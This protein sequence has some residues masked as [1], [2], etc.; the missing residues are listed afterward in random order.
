MGDAIQIASPNSI[1]Q[2]QNFRVEALRG[3][4]PKMHADVLQPWGGAREIRLDRVTGY[5]TYQ[6]VFLNAD[7]NNTGKII[8]KNVNLTAGEEIY[9]GAGGGYMMWLNTLSAEKITETEFINTYVK[10]REGRDIL[11]TVWPDKDTGKDEYRPNLTGNKVTWPGLSWVKGGLFVG[12]PPD[13]DFVKSDAAGIK[14]KS[15][16]YLK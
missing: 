7:Y 9:T 6:G 15:P 14:Y 5:S 11:K 13:G 8:F 10:A 3:D 12:D 16:G 4:G 2:I 1:V